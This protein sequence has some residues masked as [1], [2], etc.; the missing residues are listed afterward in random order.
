MG[1]RPT[2]APEDTGGRSRRIG[3]LDRVFKGVP[4]GPRRPT[5]ENEDAN[6]RFNGIN[7]LDSVFKGAV[8]AE[9]G[10]QGAGPGGRPSCYPSV[11]SIRLKKNVFALTA[12]A[13][14]V[15]A[16]ASAQAAQA[17][18]PAPPA[19]AGVTAPAP[20]VATGVP[21]K[22]AIIQLQQ[23]MLKTQDGQKASA[24]MQAKFGPRRQVLEKQQ[25]D[26]KAMQDQ[27]SKGAA[28]M[29]DAAKQKMASDIASGQKKLQRDGE[30]FDA[31]VQSYENG[32][33]QGLLTRL[34]DVIA[35]YATQNGYAMVV[36]VSSQ[37]SPLIW[38]DQAY[39]ITDA[40]VKLYDEVHPG[41]APAAAAPAVKP[42]VLPPVK[43]Q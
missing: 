43:K 36:D 12:L 27:L 8:H 23:A 5:K 30:D 37:Q 42:P 40:I 9:L 34:V 41:A 6:C 18:A 26:L 1:L 7:G 10:P 29:S 19:A 20:T 38:A 15:A 17:P 22:V 2:K 11:R 4:Y 33:Q 13:L 14:G 35:K 31:E 28:T 25:T 16:M 32:L 21:S 3:N 24:D 39:V